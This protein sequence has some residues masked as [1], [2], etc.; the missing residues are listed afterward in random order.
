L[1]VPAVRTLHTVGIQNF[2]DFLHRLGIESLQQSADYYGLALALGAG[3]ISLYEL[4]RAYSVL[5]H[6]GQLCDIQLLSQ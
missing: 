3:E 5:A 4:T 2:L 1:N 6:S